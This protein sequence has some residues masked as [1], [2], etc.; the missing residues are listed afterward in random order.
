MGKRN[1]LKAIRSSQN[2]IDEHLEKI[3]LEVHFDGNLATFFHA[4]LNS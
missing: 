1:H 3:R 2:R 4:V